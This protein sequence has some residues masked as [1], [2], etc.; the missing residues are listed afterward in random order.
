MKPHA[1]HD[2]FTNVRHA[3]T[4]HRD[5]SL[6]HL[7]PIYTLPLFF[8]NSLLSLSLSLSHTHTHTHTRARA[9]THARTHALSLSLSHTHLLPLSLSLSLS[10][11]IYLSIYLF[12][13]FSPLIPTVLLFQRFNDVDLIP[14][15][16]LDEKK[17]LTQTWFCFRFSIFDKSNENLI[18]NLKITVFP[19]LFSNTVFPL[20]NNLMLL[21]FSQIVRIYY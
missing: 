13:S 15:G 1:V 21:T 4:R 12:F 16:Y 11:S 3:F 18:Y 19:L 14:C 7:S 9:R 10:L 5:A 17:Y 6:S 20:I 2:A 8:F